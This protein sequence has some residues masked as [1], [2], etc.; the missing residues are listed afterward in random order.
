MSLTLPWRRALKSAAQLFCALFGNKIARQ[1]LGTE[2]TFAP[3]GWRHERT[4]S[5]GTTPHFARIFNLFGSRSPPIARASLAN[6]IG[7]LH[8]KGSVRGRCSARDVGTAVRFGAWLWRFARIGAGSRADRR[9][10]LSPQGRA[11]SARRTAGAM[12]A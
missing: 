1:R 10:Y 2:G 12:G 9:A 11:A 4:D 8:E 7:D 6:W 3:A 5:R